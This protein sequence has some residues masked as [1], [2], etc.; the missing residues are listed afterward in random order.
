MVR[1]KQARVNYPIKK[2][3]VEMDKKREIDMNV[4]V[5]K[6]CVSAVSCLVAGSGLNKVV[7]TC[8]YHS[9]PGIHIFDQKNVVF[10][11]GN[12]KLK[13]NL[14]LKFGIRFKQIFR[15]LLAEKLKIDEN[16]HFLKVVL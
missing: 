2:V 5:H 15:F 16:I 9:I 3:L 4:D 1:G 11:N 6:F 10:L 7:Q 13:S 8:N 12:R 14:N